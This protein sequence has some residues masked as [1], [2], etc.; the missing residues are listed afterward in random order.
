[1]AAIVM[2]LDVFEIDGRANGRMD[3]EIARVSPERRVIDQCLSVA[4]EVPVINWIKTHQC[5]K[6]PDIRFGQH[7]ADEVAL[8]R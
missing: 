4:F 2:T 5:G 1:M 8:P 7:P 6:Q 3:E